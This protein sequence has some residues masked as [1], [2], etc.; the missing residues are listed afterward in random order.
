M[1]KLLLLLFIS[2]FLNNCSY[3]NKNF[4]TITKNVKE[5]EISVTTNQNSLKTCELQL[6]A[7][8]INSDLDDIYIEV[9]VYDRKNRIVGLFNYV[10]DGVAKGKIIER[11]SNFDKISFCKIVKKIEIFAG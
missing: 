5:Y 10:I 4:Q 8:N 3:T 2:L 6:T 11:K 1:N 9:K 7:I